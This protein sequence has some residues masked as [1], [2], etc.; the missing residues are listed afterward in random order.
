MKLFGF[1]PYIVQQVSD[2][3]LLN[4]DVFPVGAGEDQGGFGAMAL[5]RV[6]DIYRI[7]Y[8]HGTGHYGGRRLQNDAA[9]TQ[10][11]ERSGETPLGPA[12]VGVAQ[13]VE[14]L[15]WDFE[16]IRTVGD[17]SFIPRS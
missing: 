16:T 14:S 8:Q 1:K 12:M 7:D 10:M 4:A 15:T 6:T 3:Y 11:C 9:V 5:L 2:Q 13:R 17:I